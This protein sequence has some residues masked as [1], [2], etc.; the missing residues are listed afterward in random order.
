MINLSDLLGAEVRNERGDELGRVRDVHVRQ[1]ANGTWEVDRLVLGRAGLAV[2]LGM[3][4]SEPATEE[5]SLAW[6]D[7]RTIEDGVVTAA[8]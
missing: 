2:R 3:P 1:T 7:V 4:T 8:A 6:N 5:N